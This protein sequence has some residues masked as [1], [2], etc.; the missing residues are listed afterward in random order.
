[1]RRKLKLF[2]IFL[3]F[4]IPI[5]YFLFTLLFFS[6]FEDPFGRIDYIIPRQVDLFFSKAGLK[7]DFYEF[8]VPKFFTE[9]EISHNWRVFTRTELYREVAAELDIESMIDQIKTQTENLPFVNV[10]DD[11]IGP[12]HCIGADD[13]KQVLSRGNCSCHR[14]WRPCR[15]LLR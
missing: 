3:I 15:N 12:E 5:L 11:F 14:D 8:P 7:E 4:A 1:M 2:G 6:P 13:H 9:L 10:L